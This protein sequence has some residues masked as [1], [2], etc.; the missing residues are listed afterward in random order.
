MPVVY[1]LFKPSLALE[2]GLSALEEKGF[3]GE[4]LAV[5]VLAPRRPGR[6]NLLDS[7]DRSDGTSLMDGM[8]IAAS[9]GMLMGVIYGSLAYVGPVAMGLAGAL[10]GGGIG[11]LLDLA[12]KKK[13]PEGGGTPSGEVIVA[14]RCRSEEEAL[15][16]E[17]I[18]LESQAAA[19]G[20]GPCL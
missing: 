19:L 2:L 6:Q 17:K 7:M 13:R 18:M 12:V 11:L 10:A 4:R 15:E 14:V 1:G 20:R 5:V 8:A 3:S 16:A 9:I